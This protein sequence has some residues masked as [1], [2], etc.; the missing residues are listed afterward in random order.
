MSV[1]GFYTKDEP[2]F[3]ATTSLRKIDKSSSLTSAK[4]VAYLLKFSRT[5]TI[6]PGIFLG[7]DSFERIRIQ[8]NLEVNYKGCN[9]VQSLSQ[10]DCGIC[11]SIYT[12]RFF[13]NIG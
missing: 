11:I 1:T 12:S 7:S 9:S 6:H 2:F 5:S 3:G 10:S 13:T 8:E 4:R